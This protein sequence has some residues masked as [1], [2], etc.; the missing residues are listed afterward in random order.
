MALENSRIRDLIDW[1]SSHNSSLHPNIE[2]YLDPV[3]GLSFRAKG[4][5]APGLT[6]VAASHQ[7]SLSYLNAIDAPGFPRH[8]PEFPTEFLETLNDDDPN[9]IS[10]FFLVQQYLLGDASFWWPYI[11]LLPQPDD[12]QSIGIPISWSQEDRRFLTGTNAEPPLQTRKKLWAAE[13]EKGITVLKEHSSNWEDYSYVLYQ[14]AASI[15]GSRSFRASLTVQ[16]SIEDPLVLEHAKKDRFS[17]LLP[18]LDIGNHNGVNN[19]DWIPD[20]GVLSLK[21]RNS[22]PAG[23]QIFNF[24]GNK[25]NSELL[26]AYGFTLPVDEA[27]GLD[28]NV[29]NLKLKA[30]PEALALRRNQ[31]CYQVPR[32]PDE[33]CTFMVQKRPFRQDGLADLSVF[34]DGLIDLIIC[35]VANTREKSYISTNP[36]YCPER[37]PSLIEGPLYR[38]ALQA[39]SVLYA[40]L[41]MEEKRIRETG[42]DLP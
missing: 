3:T 20:H 1:A 10:H 25:S 34:S 12:R 27:A 40:K 42:A 8:G 11:R 17:V 23:A 30:S 38:S 33:E 4:E 28:V 29:V 22:I 19:V 21:I 13:W 36:E 31:S 15:F 32:I 14:W 2:I 7:I 6:V 37:D 35:I 5:H 26:V 18:L 41:L 39:L 16:Q 24:Y 9:V